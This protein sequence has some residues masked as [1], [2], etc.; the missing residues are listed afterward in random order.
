MKNLWNNLDKLCL[1][2]DTHQ[3][4]ILMLDFDG[5]LS[6][7]VKYPQ[8]ANLPK[9]TKSSLQ[10]LSKKKRV[11]IAIISGRKLDDLKKK[12]GIPNLI[13]AGLHGLN[14]EIFGKK[15][16]FP[17]TKRHAVILNKIK[18]KFS[19][20]ELKFKG[21]F[22][23]DKDL[24]LSFHYRTASTRLNPAIKLFIN[25]ALKPFIEQGLICIIPGKKVFDV[26]PD[27]KWDK[28]IFATQ[29]VKTVSKKIKEKPLTI[30]IGDDQTD[31]AI[32]QNL[33]NIISVKVG[34]YE[35]TNANYY[36]KDTTEVCKFLIWLISKM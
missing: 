23:E 1:E 18:E 35:H 2:L 26:Y 11:Y 21:T 31:E 15:Y 22:I 20:A 17:L 9:E 33:K 28:G 7:I 12:V 10:S 32:F 36:L 34:K 13:Y 29:V 27:I 4:K 3:T 14:G 5:T 16:S 24:V 8:D 6:P 25:K 19:E 30:F